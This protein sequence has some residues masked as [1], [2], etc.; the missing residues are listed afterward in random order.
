M[1]LP[2]TIQVHDQNVSTKALI[3]SGA[4]GQFIDSKFEIQNRIPMHKLAKP[5]PVLNVDGTTNKDG[6]ITHYT[7]RSI[8]LGSKRFVTRLLVTG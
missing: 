8:R 3:D 5:I 7:W 6:T 4:E 1:R 2:I